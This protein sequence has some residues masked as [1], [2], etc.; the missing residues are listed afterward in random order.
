MLIDN[1]AQSYTGSLLLAMPAVRDATFGGSVVLVCA[2][3]CD[4]AMGL[5]VNAPLSRID[6][7]AV[8][9]N[10]IAL[11]AR[12]LPIHLGGPAE[13]ER[14][15]LLHSTDWADGDE[16]LRVDADHALTTSAT[17]LESVANQ[18]GP[19]AALVAL[20]YSAWGPGQLESEVRANVW[21]TAPATAEI[22]FHP[23][24]A[25]KW[26]AALRSVGAEPESLS[27]RCGHA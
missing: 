10:I 7:V 4:G 25:A 19:K 23:D 15:F 2:H 8:D 14:P 6:G 17:G 24:C 11:M 20:G 16:T 18:T 26:N 3:S 9:E 1:E 27:G 5:I 21:L 12:R 13:R 22:V